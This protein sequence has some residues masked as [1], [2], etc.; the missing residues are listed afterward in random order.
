MQTKASKAEIVG[1]FDNHLKIKIRTLP[2][3]GK[4]NKEL[5]KILAKKFGVNQQQICLLKG[6][7]AK[8]KIFLIKSPKV[9]IAGITK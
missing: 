4:A 5:I 7:K 3:D 9:L 1:E 2:I 6:E 8:K